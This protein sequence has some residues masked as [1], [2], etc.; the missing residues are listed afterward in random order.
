MFEVPASNFQGSSLKLVVSYETRLIMSPPV[1]NGGIASSSARLP[2]RKP[3]PV[4]PHILCPLAARKSTSS[5]WTS[6]GMCGTDWAAST[7][8][9]APAARARNDRFERRDRADRVRDVRQRDQ[10]HAVEQVV[11]PVQ[12]QHAVRVGRDEAQHRTGL[13]GEQLPGNEVR[14]VLELRG[15][16]RVARPEV[17]QAPRERDE[18]DRLGRVARPDDLFGV[19]GVDEARDLGARVL[20]LLGRARAKLVDAAVDV[21][22]VVLVV[23]DERVDHGLRLLRGGGRVEKDEPL[24]A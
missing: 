21:R 17:R 13:R 6:T 23:V 8:T 10:L 11:E 7:K 9:T 24:P 20:E 1:R 18:V 22:V 15:Q 12:D 2:Y 14:V 19:R 3:I 5:A 4:G 16:D